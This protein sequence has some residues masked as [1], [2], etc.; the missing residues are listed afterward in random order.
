MLLPIN[1]LSLKNLSYAPAKY[2]AL[3]PFFI[4]KPEK[5]SNLNLFSNPL[6]NDSLS[7]GSE[8]N[9]PTSLG[10][11]SGS[12]ERDIKNP[13]FYQAGSLK[14]LSPAGAILSGRY[15]PQTGVN[16][17]YTS[18]S[19]MGIN[20]GYGKDNNYNLGYTSPSG[21]NLNLN[22]SNDSY[23]IGYNSQS[24]RG[25]NI[26][27]N[28]EETSLEYYTPKS[29]SINLGLSKDK[30]SFDVEYGTEKG[31]RYGLRYDPESGVRLRANIKLNK[32]K[33]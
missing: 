10:N 15:S 16:A 11:I 5:I 3:S 32:N 22:Y 31:N 18:P 8:F 9:I 33:K 28:P 27:S 19:G 29:K 7:I 23:G 6:I 25:I 21:S 26:Q 14:Y 30:K 17:N 12:Y 2:G 20:L 13:N 1:I 24:G 4:N